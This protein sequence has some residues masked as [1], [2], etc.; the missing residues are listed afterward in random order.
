MTTR[1]EEDKLLRAP[2]VVILGGQQH[3]VK[4]LVIAEAR[5]WRKKVSR[6]L[7]RLPSYAGVTTA[8]AK[9]FASAVDAMLV[10][11]PD[12]MVDL[13]FSYAKDLNR[14]TIEQSATEAELAAA[15]GAVMEVGFPLLGSMTG[16]LRKLSQ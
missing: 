3:E 6:L 7:G 4:P 1:T 5:E 13:F 9:G 16:A 14:E 11:M 8:D 12:E 10:G 2:I 15:I